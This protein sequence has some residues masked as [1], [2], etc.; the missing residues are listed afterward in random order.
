MSM[1][2][3]FSTHRKQIITHTSIIVGFVLLVVFAAEPLFDR[4]ERIPGEAQLHRVD[5]PA[6]TGGMRTHIDELKTDGIMVEVKGWAFIEG[7]D[8][9]NTEIYIVLESGR[10]TYVFDT[11]VQMRTDVTAQFSGMDVNLDQS[12]FSALLPAR[13][14]ADGE[15][16]VGIY[17]RKGDIEALHYT[18]RSLVKSRGTIELTG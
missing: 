10:R 12:G 14:I 11:M 2:N 1:R 16:T 17:I 18:N 15:Y 5:L 4:L 8:A 3:W 13:K 9:D 6:E 7:E